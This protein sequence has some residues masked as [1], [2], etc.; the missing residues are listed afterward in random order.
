MAGPAPRDPAK[1]LR[2]NKATT[3]SVLDAS[4]DLMEWP[5]LPPLRVKRVLEERDDDSGVW[6]RR[7]WIEDRDY[8]RATVDWYGSWAEH[9]QAEVLLM[10]DRQAIARTAILLDGILAGRDHSAGAFKA[11]D[12]AMA[13]FGEALVDRWR[14]K[15]AIDRSHSASPGPVDDNEDDELAELRR[16]RSAG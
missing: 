9:P 3:S 2:R 14:M 7:E 6:T 10:S 1:L 8:Q 5:D 13:R 15:L 11:V 12:A 16:L 4:G